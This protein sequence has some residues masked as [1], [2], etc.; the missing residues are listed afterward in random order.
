MRPVPITI[1]QRR[2][3]AYVVVPR[4]VA[5][6]ELPAVVAEFIGANWTEKNRTIKAGEDLLGLDVR[7]ALNDLAATGYHIAE[8]ARHDAIAP[9]Y[10]HVLRQLFKERAVEAMRRDRIERATHMS[11]RELITQVAADVEEHAS[12]VASGPGWAHEAY[13]LR[14]DMAERMQANPGYAAALQAAA[15]EL[16]L[17]V[18]LNYQD[19]NIVNVA[20]NLAKVSI[21][22]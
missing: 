1:F 2:D 13:Y 4:G 15:P 16:A 19:N 17:R 10:T 20:E 8:P 9:Q 11:E 6:H 22:K 18:A 21:T 7:A 12:V 14:N 5:L 3:G